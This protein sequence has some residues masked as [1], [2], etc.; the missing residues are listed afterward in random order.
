[1]KRYLDCLSKTI[2]GLVFIVQV[3]LALNEFMHKYLS[4]IL[5]VVSVPVPDSY[6]MCTR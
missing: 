6:M 4:E 5:Q 3:T 2:R 1:M